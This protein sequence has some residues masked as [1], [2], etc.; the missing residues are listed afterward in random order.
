MQ[1]LNIV[2]DAALELNLDEWQ[3]N[4]AIARGILQA[5]TV[6]AGE[7]CITD[8][9][10]Q[11]AMLSGDLDGPPRFRDWL[12]DRAET[13][14]GGKFSGGVRQI[15]R[16]KLPAAM[17]AND[18]VIAYTCAIRTLGNRTPEPLLVGEDRKL[19]YATLAECYC[20]AQLRQKARNVLDQSGRSKIDLSM[21]RPLDRLYSSREQYTSIT[22]AAWSRFINGSIG[23]EKAWPDPKRPGTPIRR[24]F[25]L[26]H[27]SITG[28]IQSHMIRLAF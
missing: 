21:R 25:S 1:T 10:I 19:P 9:A 18:Q 26:P 5:E 11:T 15:L 17:P 24:H 22:N 23:I 3:I 12:D 27:S 4:R 16:D 20:V 2:A 28:L 8:E 14:R 6:S 7:Y 13:F